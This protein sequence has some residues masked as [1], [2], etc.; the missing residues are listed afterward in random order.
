MRGMPREAARLN[1]FR[2]AKGAG[3][4]DTAT[5]GGGID[6]CGGDGDGR[7]DNGRGEP[8]VAGVGPPCR[9]GRRI[10]W[11]HLHVRRDVYRPL[12]VRLARGRISQRNGDERGQ[13][14]SGP[15][16]AATAAGDGVVG[17]STS[18]GTSGVFGSNFLGG[19]GT[20]GQSNG[21][22]VGGAN[23]GASGTIASLAP[24]A[25]AAG[26]RAAN[27]GTNANGYGLWATH[28][29]SGTAAFAETPG[30]RG[31]YGLHS[32]AAGTQAGVQGE[33]NSATD[34]APGVYG[35]SPVGALGTG[36][37]GNAANGIGV[38]GV[39]GS[40]AVVGYHPAGGLAGVF[41][42]DVAVTGTLTKGAGAFRIDH[43]LDKTKYLQHSFVE[44]PD[45]KNVYDGVMR[46]DR[47]GFA[48]VRLPAYFSA[49]NRSFRY[50][51][52][53]VGR[54][55]WGAQAVV[56]Q[57]I[58]GNRFVIR[59]KPGVEVSW[60]VTGIRKDSYANAHRIQVEVAKSNAQPSAKLLAGVK[61]LR[62]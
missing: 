12:P 40:V 33:T 5:S 13:Q 47:R 32:G 30:G 60:Q 7:R 6:G 50:Q 45:M 31:V 62:K 41:S 57:K 52:T 53:L 21:N 48:T 25:T 15:R 46:T 37:Y 26:V 2:R 22:T 34:L 18:P 24:V 54:A 43:P 44:S 42:G 51:L 8:P 61:R 23:V 16:S 38:L 49:L 11:A 58:R 4:E 35:A 56:W 20:A 55:A 9:R 14:W 59:S 29:G 19:A 1:Q 28:S 10:D 27:L 39:G 3:D 17:I 36:V